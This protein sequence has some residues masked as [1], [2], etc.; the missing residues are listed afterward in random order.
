[1]KIPNPECPRED[2]KIFVTNITLS[3]PIQEPTFIIE[4]FTCNK[5]WKGTIE[6]GVKTYEE[7]K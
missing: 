6:N 4:C 5:K 1:M 3:N 7:V 2:C